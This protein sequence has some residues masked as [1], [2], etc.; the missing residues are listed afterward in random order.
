VAALA[1]IIGTKPFPPPAACRLCGAAGATV[2]GTRD[3]TGKALRTVICPGC[4]LVWTDPPLANARDYYR[5]DYR[6]AYKGTYAPKAKHVLRAG[7]VALSRYAAMRDFLPAPG[8]GGDVSILD[9]GAGGGEFIYLLHTL[10]YAVK[11]LEPNRGYAEYAIREYGLDL[12]VGF[13]QDADASS[14]TFRFVTLWHVLE[15]LEDPVAALGKI[16]SLLDPEGVLIVEVPNVEAVC[17]SPAGT[18]HEAHLFY[19]NSATLRELLLASGFRILSERV[20]G[21]GGNLFLAARKAPPDAPSRRA[22][23]IR[24]NAERIAAVVLAHT[25]LR[26][27]LTARPYVRFYRRLCRSLGEKW[28]VRR[29]PGGKALLDGLYSRAAR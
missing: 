14:G 28:A 4:G 12:D 17:Q 21:D 5:D 15:H 20:S 10:G 18:F 26:H 2:I 3:R 1:G 11:G 25:P 19:F 6:K 9:I 29:F 16:H 8:G 22:A 24:G 23:E 27:Y 13:V 7:Q